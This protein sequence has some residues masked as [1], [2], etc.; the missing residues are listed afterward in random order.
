[1][2]RRYLTLMSLVGIVSM[3][4]VS[5]ASSADWPMWRHDANRSASSLDSQLPERLHLQ[6]TRNYAVPR[7]AWK[8]DERVQFDATYEPIVVGQTM[9]VS[10]AQTDSVTAIDTRTGDEKWRFFANGPVRFAPV[11]A[12]GKVFFGAD[13]GFF[14]CVDAA[15]G[16]QEWKFNATPNARKVLGNER[17]ISVWPVRG[18]P[19]LHNQRIW[20]IAGVWPFE[21][22]FLYSF[23]INDTDSQPTVDIATLP[24]NLLPQGYLAAN[25]N[26]LFIPTGRGTV[27]EFVFDSREFKDLRYSARG[28]TDYH[29]TLGEK[30]MFHGLRIYD[31]E[32]HH[33]TKYQMNRPV[34][35]GQECYDSQPTNDIAC[36][37]L[38]SAVWSGKKDD[39]GRAIMERDASAKWA[40]R[41]QDIL[42]ATP[43]QPDPESRLVVALRAGNRIYGYWDRIVFAVDIP[44]ESKRG[45]VSWTTTLSEP[46]TAMLAADARLY[47]V[48]Q[49]GTLQCFGGE[50]VDIKHHQRNPVDVAR[51]PQSARVAQLLEKTNAT[52]GYCVVIGA[53]ADEL[54]DE[55]LL[56]SDL[57]LI[58]LD[59][60]AKKIHAVR[61]R[62][63]NSDLYGKRI[64]AYVGD[65]ATFSL[66]PYLANL[67]IA[68]NLAD[69]GIEL[70]AD[71]MGAVQKTLRP[72]G[73]TAVLPLDEQQHAKLLGANSQL[74]IERSDNR[75]FLVRAGA[76]PGSADW[77]DEYSNPANTLASK[78]QLVRAPL[79][80]LWYGGPASHPDLFYDRH[81]WSPGLAVIEGRMFIEGPERLTAVDVYTGRILW[82][83]KLKSGLSPGRR[84]NWNSTGFHLTLARDAVYLTYEKECVL[85]D[86]ATGAEIKKIR[87][88]DP[89]DSFGRIRI[90]EDLMI[91]PVFRNVDVYG[92]VP[93]KILAMNRHEGSVVWTKRSDYSFP[94]VAIGNN[95]VFLFEGLM[96][97]LYDNRKRG[98]R[99]P[100]A[101]PARNV[102][103][104]DLRTGDE[105]WSG[106]TDRVVTWLSYSEDTDVVIASNK[107]GVEGW[108]GTA[109]KKLWTK[110]A[111]GEGFLGH[112]ENLWDKVVLWKD[113]VID[114]R[115]PGRSYDLLTGEPVIRK[116]PLTGEEIEWQFTKNGHHCGYA[117][118]CENLLTFR[119]G[120]AG[121]L[122]LETGGTTHLQGFRSGCRNS[123][124]PAN[125]VLS[126]PN[127][128]DE[129]VCSYP[130]FTSLSLTHIPQAEKWS[131]TALES[132]TGR[133]RR[134]GVNFGAPG[135]RLVKDGSLWLDYP[136]VGGPSPD[137]E[138]K[139]VPERPRWFRNHAS[140]ISGDG[141]TWVAS[142]GGEG[143]E[144]MS[145]SLGD[146]NDTAEYTVRLYFSEPDNVRPGERVFDVSIGDSAVLTDFD[147]VKAAGGRNRIIVK[148]F[149]K[150]SLGGVLKL[151]LTAKQ[152][153]PIICGL[154]A[155]ATQPPAN[156]TAARGQ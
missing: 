138:I 110:S 76:L 137:V 97:D 116:H 106:E 27:M 135:D 90:Q 62:F 1:M 31:S 46:P 104:L 23:D 60:D 117:V 144:S 2:L 139:T 68:D 77:T 65:P 30:W 124:I 103:A 145:L 81:D 78:D 92:N 49:D 108:Q 28:V 70:N 52:E 128:A 130:I 121:F 29:V 147:P 18:G 21:G 19:V 155:I 123:L 54:I 142:S 59:P 143:L 148:E 111:D 98:G 119:A 129:C 5:R 80:L 136:S 40:V 25:A 51:N 113:Q 35:A 112:P 9:F 63:A 75:S 73:G 39:A 91:V 146:V 134:I 120:S 36:V 85:F 86:P 84:A 16:E 150:V 42:A 79:G 22:A 96:E 87:L 141:L 118:G 17:L 13:D 4:A 7:P 126:A 41:S 6:W 11:A 94:F 105:L 71:L 69:T 38:S 156:Q 34:S 100:E 115:G 93:V 131:Y 122:D 45:V 149:K 151:S 95:R 109:G 82:Q 14:Y 114:Q 132:V 74:Q 66:P 15:T 140:Q 99:V 3:F 72:Y 56:Q 83:N 88:P 153:K 47:V 53:Q 133:V 64:V 48:S 10:S 33:L 26:G 50:K 57:R 20:F 58:V 37:D 32:H 101:I 43:F 125:G 102:K 154:E 152:G 24:T 12:Q 89:G 127:F 44:R 67:V 107:Q 8:E 61:Q 55:L